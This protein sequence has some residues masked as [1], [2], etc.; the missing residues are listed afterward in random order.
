MKRRVLRPVLITG[1]VVLALAMAA[2]LYTHHEDSRRNTMYDAHYRVTSTAGELHKQ[3]FVADL[4]ADSLL[5]DRDLHEKSER[6]HVD[7]PRLR[8]GRVGLQ[9]FSIVNDVPFGLNIEHNPTQHIDSIAPLSLAQWWPPVTWFSPFERALW[10]AGKLQKLATHN[11]DFLL[12]QSREDFAQWQQRRAKGEAVIGALLAIEGAQ[13]LADDIANGNHAQLDAL[14]DAGVRMIGLAHFFD[15]GFAGSAHGEH[16][17]GLTSAGREL[18]AA[19]EQR[20]IIVDLAHV[21]PAAFDEVLT[22]ATRPVV[23]SHTGIRATCDN[24]RNLSDEQLRR[25]AAN[26]GLIGI[27]FWEIASCGRNAEA[28]AR[29]VRHAVEIAGPAHVALGSDFD[30]SVAVPF[31][32]SRYAELTSALLDTGLDQATVRRV[33]GGNVEA[34]VHNA[35]P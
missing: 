34:F 24:R 6:G 15:N 29:A 7:L 16:K 25:V 30:G 27:G 18:I 11:A 23:I 21:S 26:G 17:G 31:D 14:R 35:L 33:M 5:W 4:H 9:V 13:P 1:F 2:R 10:Q 32:A 22:I 3:L 20:K 8:E 12:L 28:I 19:L